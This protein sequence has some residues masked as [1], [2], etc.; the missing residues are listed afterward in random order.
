MRGKIIKNRGW[1]LINANEKREIKESTRIRKIRQDEQDLQDKA[2]ADDEGL[3]KQKQEK[4]DETA[5]LKSH[6]RLQM[7]GLSAL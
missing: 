6:L 7:V 4:A 1:T 5:T 2:G 3:E